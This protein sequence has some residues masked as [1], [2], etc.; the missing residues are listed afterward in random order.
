LNGALVFYSCVLSIGEVLQD[1]I[2]IEIEKTRNCFTV[3]LYSQLPGD[4]S[5]ANHTG[6]LRGSTRISEVA[7]KAGELLTSTFVVVSWEEMVAVS[8]FSSV[9][10]IQSLSCV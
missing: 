8:R 3:L 7:K 4:D 10:F 1:Q 9:Q 6:S 2:W 5:R